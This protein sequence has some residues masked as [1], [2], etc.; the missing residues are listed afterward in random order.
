MG[1]AR[2]A[3]VVVAVALASIA[4]PAAAEEPL[5]SPTVTHASIGADMKDYYRGER[6]TAF[7]F[8]GIGVASAGAGA[9]LATRDT[10]FA[11][12]LG[13]SMIAIGG[14]EAIGAI[15]YAF[16]VG[17]EVE[18]YT[19]LHANDP[20][21][22]QREEAAHIHGTTSR[23]FWYRTG[24]LVLALAGAG[25]ATYGFA[26]DRDVWKGAGI[27]IGGEALTFFILDAFG[28]ARAHAYEDH[29]Q[30]FTPSMALTPGAGARPWS[31]DLTAR[32]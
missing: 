19:A 22:F 8:T 16:Q 32:F 4:A 25:I 13:W 10:D 1:P 23:F 9:F 20:V 15:F 7:L 30:R 6:N 18:H 2:L 26:S 24:E 3:A 17:A 27:G 5:A 14:L 31:I 29:L 11:R 28:A 21:A 12:G